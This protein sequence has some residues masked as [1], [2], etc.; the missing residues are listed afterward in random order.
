MKNEIENELRNGNGV[1]PIEINFEQL[2]GNLARIK[3]GPTEKLYK[4]SSLLKK[5]P[6]KAIGEVRLVGGGEG[7][8]TDPIEGLLVSSGKLETAKNEMGHLTPKQK[9]AFSGVK[10]N[11]DG[12][13]AWARHSKAGKKVLN[14]AVVVS[15]ALS[16]AG[17]TQIIARPI[18]TF[19]SPTP[20]TQTFTPDK[21][22]T[23]V[24]STIVT[25]NPTETK[26][27][28]ETAIP[29]ENATPTETEKAPA[30]TEW[31]L[32]PDGHIYYKE[33]E[34]FDGMFTINK[35]H[36]EWVEQYWE[37]LVRGLWNLNYVGENTAFLSQF[38]TD[39]SL[40]KHF[41]NGGKP[42]YNL[43]IPSIYPSTKR[44][45]IGDAELL[46]TQGPIDLSTIAIS[47][48]K[49][50]VQ[51]IYTYNP[52]YASGAKFISFYGAA[53]SVWIKEIQV[54]GKPILSMDFRKYLLMDAYRVFPATGQDCIGGKELYISAFNEN[55]SSEDN[56]L[57]ATQL[58]RLWVLQMEEKEFCNMPLF[59]KSE[60]PPRLVFNNFSP[61]YQDVL[62]ISTLDGT[63][64]SLR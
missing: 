7:M 60:T 42:V 41:R 29:T 44:Q 38:P 56:L 12:A 53:A 10:E 27:S 51:E 40:V 9:E 55:K 63:P 64:L 14:S 33:S 62:D 15:L 16:S 28:T 54:N 39:D 48:Y 23:D 18:K 2:S 4:I 58:I 32:S 61:M 45:H 21:T 25:P 57:A 19:E 31:Q 46:P 50:T 11:I 22:E 6:F 34:L 37:D 20:I 26:I 59:S 24:N 5:D 1:G 36:P 30:S 47:I 35:E 52:S 8:I 13:I 3:C 49:P 43:L 17:C